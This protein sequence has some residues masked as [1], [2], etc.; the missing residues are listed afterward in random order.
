MKSERTNDVA[1]HMDMLI[2]LGWKFYDGDTELEDG[3]QVIDAHRGGNVQFRVPP[4][5]EERAVPEGCTIVTEIDTEI[6]L[7]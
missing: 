7:E 1:Q 2:L 3:R 5:W 6:I 4:G